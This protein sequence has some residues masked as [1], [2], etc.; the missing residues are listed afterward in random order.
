MTSGVNFFL[1]PGEH[2]AVGLIY[3]DGCGDSIAQ[4]ERCY[5][6]PRQGA[7]SLHL[8][9]ECFTASGQALVTTSPQPSPSPSGSIHH[10]IT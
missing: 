5:E 6:V 2:D 3:C 8:H 9:D 10:S 4:Y 7:P 1:R